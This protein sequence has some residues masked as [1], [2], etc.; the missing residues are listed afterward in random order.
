MVAGLVAAGFTAV[1]CANNVT[2]PPRALLESL[3]VL[4]RAGIPHCGGGRTGEE[5]H[6]PVIVSR[7]GVRLG[8]LAY[9][10]V[11]W[12]V[13]HAAGAT[14]PGVATI[15]A[16]TAYQP[17]PR[18][19]E[20]PGGAPRVLTTPDAE[21]L[22][23]MA[24]DVRRLREQV[25][26]VVVSCHWG[27][28][29]STQVADYQQAIGRAAIDAGAHVVIGHGPH[30]VQGIEVWRGRPIFYSLG[31][32]AFDWEAMRRQR[33]G[34]LVRCTI[35]DR[36]LARA[37]FAPITRDDANC[38]LLLLPNDEVGKAVV[39]QVRELSAAYGTS[40][41]LEGDEVVVDL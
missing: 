21:E 24:A 2:Y 10:S 16:S 34:L 5:A 14:T 30:R 12:P 8:F 25:D 20:M 3:A 40:L 1:G 9:T 13:G 19:A 11:F 4:D 33:D 29:G 28:S 23:A 17:H 7:G 18:I 27:V 15:R 41:H 6:Q 39:T 35:R 37:A 22:A 31:N 38:P 26:V 32:F 36:G